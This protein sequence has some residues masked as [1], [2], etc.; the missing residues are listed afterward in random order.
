MPSVVD[1]KHLHK[2]FGYVQALKN[3]TFDLKAGEKVALL[4]PNGSGKSTLIKII[5]GQMMPST[6]S[7]KVF[8]YDVLKE[9][10]SVKKRVGVVGHKSY[11]YD[12]LTVQENLRFYGQ[13]FNA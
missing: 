3:I 12:E 1:A 11:L 10:E 5:S 2:K 8:Q 6:G 7:L 9:R 4:G 13:F